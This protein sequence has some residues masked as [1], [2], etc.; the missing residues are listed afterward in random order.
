M[1]PCMALKKLQKQYNTLEEGKIILQPMGTTGNDSKENLTV[2]Y[3]VISMEFQPA[4]SFY[5]YSHEEREIIT[6]HIKRF[7]LNDPKFRT[8]QLYDFIKNIVDNNGK[9]PQYEY[10]NIIIE[11]FCEKLK[12]KTSAE[13]L[14]ICEGIYSVIFLKG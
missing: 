2:Q 13:I 14:K 4:D 11:L 7:K 12:N 8:R 9:I 5:K 1:V 6:T 10:N 3:D